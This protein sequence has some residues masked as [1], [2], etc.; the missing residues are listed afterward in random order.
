MR[1]FTIT[2]LAVTLVTACGLSLVAR[3]V[4]GLTSEP[5]GALLAVDWTCYPVELTLFGRSHQL[6]PE[7]WGKQAA[8][9][10]DLFLS[11]VEDMLGTGKIKLINGSARLWKDI[12]EMQTEETL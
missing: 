9:Q 8:S 10:A 11:Q 5:A 6:Q 4:T 12:K 3:E 7:N 2:L 1:A